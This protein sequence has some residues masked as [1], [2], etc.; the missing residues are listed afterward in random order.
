[1]IILAGGLSKVP[2]LVDDL[3]VALTNAQFKGFPI[4]EIGIAKGGD[5]S[6]ALGA[7]YVAWRQSADD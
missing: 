6:G 5:A 1:L 7:A 3:K 4:P 2:H